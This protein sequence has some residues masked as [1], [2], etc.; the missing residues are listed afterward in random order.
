MKPQKLLI[1]LGLLASFGAAY[2]LTRKPPM[3]SP[4]PFVLQAGSTEPQVNP[5]QAVFLIF[6]HGVQRDFSAAMYLNQSSDVYIEATNPSIIHVKQSGVTW[7]EFFQTLPFEL[8]RDCL[9][10]GTGQQFC[11]GNEGTLTFFLNG[12][13]TPEVLQQIIQPADRLLISFGNENETQLK[14]QF[15][16]IPQPE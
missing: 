2:W 12:N 13:N 14:K 16:Q 4:E 3:P 9:T 11:T 1:L 8:T 5:Y 7:N 15:D 10:T 6:T